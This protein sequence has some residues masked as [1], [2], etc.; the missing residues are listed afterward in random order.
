M[1]IP[2]K[3][4][5][6]AWYVCRGVILTK[7]DLIKQN[8]HGSK[9]CVFCPQDEIIKHL[10]FQCNF[11]RS[12]WSVIQEAS[13]LHPPTSITNIFGNWLHDINYKYRILLRVGA[14]ALIW[15]LW[16]CRNDKVFNNKY[17][18]LLPVIYRCTSMVAASSRG[19]SRLLYGGVYAYGGY[20]EGPL[21]STWMSA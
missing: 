10:F 5:S 14:I 17:S 7:D 2:L 16:L 20:G 19:G 3:N 1:K 4:K 6:F 11:A 9:T 18:S 15:S 13:G 12:I 21:F 8:W